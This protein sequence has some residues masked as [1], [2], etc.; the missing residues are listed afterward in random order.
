MIYFNNTKHLKLIAYI[1]GIVS[2]AFTYII[3]FLSQPYKGYVCTL[4]FPI[5]IRNGGSE[6]MSKVLKPGEQ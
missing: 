3:Y 5:Q 1:Q 2:D 4:I 6:R